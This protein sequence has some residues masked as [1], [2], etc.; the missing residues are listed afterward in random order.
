MVDPPGDLV[1]LSDL[2][3]GTQGSDFIETDFSCQ[4]A[5]GVVVHPC[6]VLIS[7]GRGNMKEVQLVRMMANKV[8]GG[9]PWN[10]RCCE[11][12]VNTTWQ[13]NHPID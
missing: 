6:R 8:E 9:T 1:K 2:R 13:N 5:S 7:L 4:N 10:M 3:R 11:L 12:W